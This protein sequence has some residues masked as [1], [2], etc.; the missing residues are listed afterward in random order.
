A[1]EVGSQ[2]LWQKAEL[3]IATVSLTAKDADA[4]LRNIEEYVRI[5]PGA[6]VIA[7][8]REIFAL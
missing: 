6:I 2:D 7:V 8:E 5:Q 1:S 4:K 3:G